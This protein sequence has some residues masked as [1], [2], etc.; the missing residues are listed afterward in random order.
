M[1]ALRKKI[2]QLSHRYSLNKSKVIMRR[3]QEAKNE[4]DQQYKVLE[5]EYIAIL[6]EETES[7]FKASNTAKAWKVVIPSPMEKPCNR[8][9]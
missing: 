8:V 6:I 9:S 2:N 4:L 1:L 3:L 5:E 7:E